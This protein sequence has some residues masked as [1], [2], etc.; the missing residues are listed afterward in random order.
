LFYGYMLVKTIFCLFFFLIFL[1][2]SLFWS[3]FE[4]FRLFPLLKGNFPVRVVDSHFLRM[5]ALDE[6]VLLFWEIFNSPCKGFLPQDLLSSTK[7]P[8]FPSPYH[9]IKNQNIIDYFIFFWI[10]NQLFLCFCFNTLF[11]T[12]YLSFSA[13]LSY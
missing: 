2:F 5:I 1:V 13:S 12:S 10:A 9:K 7:Y 8:L 6:E 3:F 11:I 4:I